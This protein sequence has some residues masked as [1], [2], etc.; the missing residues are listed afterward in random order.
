[1]SQIKLFINLD[2]YQTIIARDNLGIV[3]D[4]P[5]KILVEK[6]GN[7]E[8]V[9]A[10]AFGQRAT[11]RNDE[12]YTI[13]PIL[14]GE[15]VDVENCGLMMKNYVERV[16]ESENP[17]IKAYVSVP[18]GLTLSN[19]QSWEEVLYRADISTL[20]KVPAPIADALDAD[21]DLS[22]G[23]YYLVID[24]GAG[25][26]DVA[27]VS[28]N[29]IV[30]G[31]TI[32]VGAFNMDM[33]VVSQI[34][35]KHATRVG[36]EKARE[37]KVQIGTLLPNMSKNLNVVGVDSRTGEEKTAKVT[38]FDI[39]EALQ[40]F[41]QLIMDTVPL[42]CKDIPENIMQ[43]INSNAVIICGV[44]SLIEGL[45]IYASERLKMDVVITKS[46]ENVRGLMAL[47]NDKTLS[48]KML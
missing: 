20:V 15:I 19:N 16:V 14:E 18:C 29:G 17:K 21:V 1:M 11:K 27:I 9:R 7:E 4:E 23:K 3:L 26:T 30:K 28:G 10:I 34:Q 32:N 39:L 45:D 43:S 31:M 25:S 6:I 22:D 36:I 44:G 33:A 12:Q 47:S 41:Y 48:K 2:S 8:N 40:E 46:T 35:A 38:C 24:I 5:T 37:L 42:L 13:N